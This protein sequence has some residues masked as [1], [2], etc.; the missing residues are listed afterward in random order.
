MNNFSVN[1]SQILQGHLVFYLVVSV[2]TTLSLF[3]GTVWEPYSVALCVEPLL[4]AGH[5]CVLSH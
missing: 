2:Y 3:S 5:L 4:C 1:T